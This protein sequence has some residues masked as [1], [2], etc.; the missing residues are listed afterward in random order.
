VAILAS[1]GS[2]EPSGEH[3][4]GMLPHEPHRTIVPR[5]QAQST[6]YGEV[7]TVW[8][9]L[10]SVFQQVHRS[11]QPSGLPG[12]AS[13]AFWTVFQKIIG[14]RSHL[15]LR[16]PG[17]QA[18]EPL[19]STRG[20]SFQSALLMDPACQML[21]SR[22]LDH[23]ALPQTHPKNA[24]GSTASSQKIDSLHLDLQNFSIPFSNS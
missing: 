13:C 12:I 19:P 5:R 14:S 17:L 22:R 6:F 3:F 24:P 1:L 10:W 15:P 20:P 16:Y 18:H 11:T 7:D 9:Q 4:N 2:G 23:Q 8:N 21:C